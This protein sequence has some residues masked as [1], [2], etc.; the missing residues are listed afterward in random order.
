MVMY[1]TTNPNAVH[2]F[3]EAAISEVPFVQELPQ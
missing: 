1:P 2:D 3:E